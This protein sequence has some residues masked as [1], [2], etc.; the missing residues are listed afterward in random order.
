M[1]SV[2]IDI[3]QAAEL[4]DAPP[5]LWRWQGQHPPSPAKA[6]WR[7]VNDLPAVARDLDGLPCLVAEVEIH[8]SVMRS[9]AHVRGTRYAIEAG[10]GRDEV[11]R[12]GQGFTVDCLSGL[13]K[14]LPGHELPE[15][16]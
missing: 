13:I 12:R 8:V 11:D 16:P 10:L 1:P 9:H 5:A 14:E 4:V 3:Q 15:F 2:I 6:H 7:V